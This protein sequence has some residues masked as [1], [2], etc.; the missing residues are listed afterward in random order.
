MLQFV[1]FKSDLLGSFWKPN[2]DFSLEIEQ[3]C[4]IWHKACWLWTKLVY[5]SEYVQL[6][7]E[8]QTRPPFHQSQWM[9]STASNAFVRSMKNL[10]LNEL[11]QS[12]IC[13]LKRCFSLLYEKIRIHKLAPLT[14]YLA[15][16]QD[17]QCQFDVVISIEWYESSNIYNCWVIFIDAICLQISENPNE[18]P[19]DYCLI[20]LLCQFNNSHQ[21]NGCK[22]IDCVLNK[23]QF[24]LKYSKR[25][26]K[27][28][29]AT[30]F[31]IG[32]IHLEYV[33][34]NERNNRYKMNFLYFK[35]LR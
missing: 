25:F 15:N 21:I 10:I 18:N 26:H 32:I 13:T 23:Q 14:Y 5:V 17:L 16:R 19:V 24:I 12:C 22:R 30:H 1:Q 20:L 8:I 29:T 27:N 28:T 33:G 6:F 9:F 11:A 31:I 2:I 4:I 35:Y 7:I 34:C 3:F